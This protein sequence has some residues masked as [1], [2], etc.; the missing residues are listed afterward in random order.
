VSKFITVAAVD[1]LPPGERLVAAVDELYIAVFNVGGRLYAIEDACTHDDGPLIEGR[2]IDDPDNPKIE[3]DR[4][5]ATFELKTGK[6]TFPAV[7]PARRFPVRIEGDE[8][9]I[10]I[11]GAF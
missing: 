11:G 7:L 5:G 3:C 4:H 8:I 2:L 9:Q 1:Q 6:P 10:D